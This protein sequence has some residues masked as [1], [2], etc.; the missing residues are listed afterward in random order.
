MPCLCLCGFCFTSN[1]RCLHAE[2]AQARSSPVTYLSTDLMISKTRQFSKHICGRGNIAFAWACGNASKVLHK[3]QKYSLKKG[4]CSIEKAY[5]KTF[6]K[7][8]N[9]LTD[10]EIQQ[11]RSIHEPL[12]I[13][14][15][16]IPISWLQAG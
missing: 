9:G 5:I 6:L 10:D 4:I 2:M 13:T 15:F 16:K 11:G 8:E 12:A 1:M 14:A 3:M 7:V